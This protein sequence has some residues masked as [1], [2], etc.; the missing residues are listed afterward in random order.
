M[1]FR[2][3]LLTFAEYVASVPLPK[4]VTT[5]PRSDARPT[6][7]LARSDTAE[8]RAE[9]N[10]RLGLP[11]MP[12]VLGL[13]ALPLSIT[14]PREGRYARVPAAI[15]IFFVYIFGSIGLTGFS[16]RDPALGPM[17]YWSLHGAVALAALAAFQWRQNGRLLPRWAHG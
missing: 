15:A 5:C 12:L 3:R 4:N 16:A 13:I 6:L 9:L 7:D 11:L 8:D 1:L 10:W 14:R 2:S 17:A